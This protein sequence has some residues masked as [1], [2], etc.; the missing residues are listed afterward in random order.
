[1]RISLWRSRLQS[2]INDRVTVNSWLLERPQM[3]AQVV[4]FLPPLRDVD[5]RRDNG[6]TLVM[7]A[8][9]DF[10]VTQRL[11][12]ELAFKDLPLAA[13]EGYY[14][15]LAIAFMANYSDIHEDVQE[16]NFNQIEQP[17]SIAEVAEDANDWIVDIKWSIRVQIL[18]EP[19]EGYI[20]EPFELRQ[21]TANVYRDSLADD[22]SYGTS[23]P[24]LRVL[25]FSLQNLYDSNA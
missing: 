3:Y 25:D 18:V 23:D 10:I 14:T 11:P 13:I 8:T 16:L 2:F 17:I 19:E 15:T 12:S 24:T 4:G 1:M 7:T 21:L 5:Y 22:T 20:I 6:I 9:Q